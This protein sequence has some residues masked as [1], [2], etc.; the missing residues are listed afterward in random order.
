MQIKPLKA[1]VKKVNQMVFSSMRR[2]KGR[3][4]GALEEVIIRDNWL[5]GIF[6]SLIYDK[7]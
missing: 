4:K 6:E 7:K 5:N 3:Q 1:P 2:G